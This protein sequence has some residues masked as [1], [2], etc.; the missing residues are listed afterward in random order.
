MMDIGYDGRLVYEA[1]RISLQ[2]RERFHD[3]NGVLGRSR[4]EESPVSRAKSKFDTIRV[5]CRD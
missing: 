5:I 1:S 2:V 4:A 3:R